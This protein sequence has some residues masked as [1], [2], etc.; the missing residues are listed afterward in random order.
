MPQMTGLV[1]DDGGEPQDGWDDPVRG[2]V[3]WRTLFS[4]D[5][6]ESFG[7]TCGVAVL[8]PGGW[9]GLHRHAAAEV[10]QVL[11]GDGRVT[12][13]GVEHLVRAGSA[14]SIPSDVEHGIRNV[15]HSTLRFFY[16]LAANSFADVEY[17][18]T[19]DVG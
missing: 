18:F 3:S 13:S 2:R 16:C 11:Q 15:G 7:L 8:E 19:A 12:L 10:Y 14:V 6:T 1:R 17:R 4:G 5:V 9:L